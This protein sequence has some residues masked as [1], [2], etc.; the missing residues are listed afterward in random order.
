[1]KKK[2]NPKPQ[3]TSL[4]LHYCYFKCNAITAPTATSPFYWVV[5]FPV[6]LG[7]C[8]IMKRRK[9]AWDRCF[10]SCKC[11]PFFIQE[12]ARVSQPLFDYSFQKSKALPHNIYG[13]LAL[14]CTYELWQHPR[15]SQAL[16]LLPREGALGNQLV[17]EACLMW[18]KLGDE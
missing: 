10:F 1:M 7:A 4:V 2:S 16:F 8:G 18:Q 9:G 17:N 5:V 15:V 11:H 6:L 12:G 3:Q 14:V 13:S